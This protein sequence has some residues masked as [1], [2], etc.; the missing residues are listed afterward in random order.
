MFSMMATFFSTSCIS[1]LSRYKQGKFGINTQQMYIFIISM[2]TFMSE[3]LRYITLTF[4]PRAIA[5][6]TKNTPIIQCNLNQKAKDRTSQ[7]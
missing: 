4:G 2:L 3:N 5:N 1:S 6:L 7:S